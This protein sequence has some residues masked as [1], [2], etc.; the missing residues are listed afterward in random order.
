[1]G[2]DGFGF[3]ANA[4]CI[5]DV[6]AREQHVRDGHH[7]RSLVDRIAHLLRVDGDAVIGLDD[8]TLGAA[9]LFGLPHVRNRGELQR[10]VHDLVALWRVVEAGG[11]HRLDLRHVVAHRNRALGR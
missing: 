4:L 5:L 3:L 8:V 9:A 7:D 2:A 11:H 1:M 10:A 6:S